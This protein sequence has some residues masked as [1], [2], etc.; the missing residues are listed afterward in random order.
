[1]S[2]DKTAIGKRPA[3][4]KGRVYCDKQGTSCYYNEEEICV[5]CGRPKGWRRAIKDQRRAKEAS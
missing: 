3:G 1:M 2:V 5:N 4:G